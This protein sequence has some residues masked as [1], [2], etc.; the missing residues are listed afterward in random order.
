MDRTF[1]ILTCH[2]Y[3]TNW[4]EFHTAVLCVNIFSTSFGQMILY[5]LFR[6]M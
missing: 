1:E 3:L 4:L 5:S 6:S 2:S